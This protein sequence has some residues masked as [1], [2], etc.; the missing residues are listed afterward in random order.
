MILL[1]QRDCFTKNAQEDLLVFRHLGKFSMGG[2]KIPLRKR[3]S[4]RGAP[5]IYFLFAGAAPANSLLFAGGAPVNSFLFAGG[6]P[7]NSFLFA[8]G[9]PANS[10]FL[11]F[12][13]RNQNYYTYISMQLKG[14]S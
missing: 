8:G 1:L 5:A 11:Y 12:F 4:A 10:L 6:T 13:N 2:G 3:L 14:G 9:A 7:A